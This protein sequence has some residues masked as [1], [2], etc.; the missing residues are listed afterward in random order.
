MTLTAWVIIWFL[1][2]IASSVIASNKGYSAGSWFLI[3][4]L[5]GPLA[6]LAVL[7]KSKSNDEVE[8]QALK[9]GSAIKC[10][11]CAETIKAEARVC[12]HC[13][14]DIPKARLG[15]IVVDE[16]QYKS[17]VIGGDINKLKQLVISGGDISS[18]KDDLLEIAIAFDHAD[19]SEYLKNIR[20]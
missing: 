8:N 11:F 4:F 14:R 2:G 18:F 20:Q 5:F 1:C 19:I 13:G 15:S 16:S 17:A 7:T 3:G 6:V 12:K 10:P 9:D